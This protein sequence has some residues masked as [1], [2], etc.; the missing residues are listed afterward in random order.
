M[1]ILALIAS[2]GISLAA[3]G[4]I[5]A[6]EY[7]TPAN[8]VISDILPADKITGPHYRVQDVVVSYGYMDHFTV[9]SDYG[10]FEVTGD[11]A[12]RKLLKEIKAIAALKEVKKGK[13]YAESVVKAGTMPLEFSK[14]LITHPVDT[15]TGIPKGAFSL[16]GNIFTSVTHKHDPSEDPRYATALAVSSYKRQYAHQLGVDVYS[17]NRVLQKE[18]NSVAWAGA[19]G[20]LT[21][22]AAMVP[23]GGAA[24]LAFKTTRLSQQFNNL[25]KEQPPA[26]LRQINYKKLSDMGVWED[27]ANKYLDHPSFTPRHDTIIVGSLELLGHGRGQDAFIKH[28]LSADDEVSANFFQNMAEPLRGYHTTVSPIKEIKVVGILVYARAANGSVMIP[29][30]LDHG[31]WSAQADRAIKHAISGYRAMASGASGKFELW[32]TGTV[33]PMAKRQVKLHGIE[34][35]ENVD[36]RIEFMD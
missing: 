16:V 11:G 20:S 18:L 8:R 31:V 12:L 15:V 29:F 36:K 21:V 2:L 23:F 24:A 7:E 6:A 26:K 32:V 3:A 19:L 10:V 14:N 5:A 9:N 30:P 4:P 34:V 17:S 1:K 28:A 22:T 13:A 27:L 33:T 25:L 35:V